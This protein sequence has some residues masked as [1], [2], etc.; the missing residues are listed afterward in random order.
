METEFD[1]LRTELVKTKTEALEYLKSILP[2]IESELLISNISYYNHLTDV[3]NYTDQRG[4]KLFIVSEFISLLSLHI[5]HIKETKIPND[6][7]GDSFSKIQEKSQQYIFTSN[8]INKL[9]TQKGESDRFE[10]N[11]FQLASDIKEEQSHIRN[12]AIPEHYEEFLTSLYLNYNDILKSKLGFNVDEAFKIKKGIVN[13]INNRIYLVSEEKSKFS[14]VL[15]KEIKYF[16]KKKKLSHN[17]ILTVDEINSFR[18]VSNDELFK[19]LFRMQSNNF[20][21][22]IKKC[23]SINSFLLSE[24]TG[25][26]QST[27]SSFLNKFSISFGEIDRIYDMTEGVTPLMSKPIISNGTNF[28]ISSLPLLSGAIGKVLDSELKQQKGKK[29]GLF[30]NFKHDFLLEKSIS[31]FAKLLNNP[32]HTYTNVDYYIDN[33]RY[34]LD[35][36]IISDNIAFIIEVKTQIFSE[37]AKKGYYQRIKKHLNDIITDSHSQSLRA[38]KL[39]KN[40]NE[41][42]IF[43]KNSKKKIINVENIDRFQSISVTLESLSHI[44][45]MLKTSNELSFF[46]DND[47]P[48]IICY[49]DLIIISD[50]LQSPSQFSLYLKRRE[51]FLS[52]KNYYTFDEIDVLSYFLSHYLDFERFNID[53]SATLFLA[54]ATDEIN[55]Y[56][57]YKF[58][59]SGKKVQKPKLD[60]SLEFQRIINRVEE[61]ELHYRLNICELLH[62]LSNDSRN[63]FI[64]YLKKI[65]KMFKSDKELHDFSLVGSEKGGWGITYMTCENEEKLQDKLVEYCSFKQRQQETLIWVGIGDSGLKFPKITKLLYLKRN[66]T[67][68]KVQNG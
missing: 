42:E 2:Q 17:G 50:L 44:S 49:Y 22:E 51:V 57:M 38:R 67:E 53:D 40:K 60:I 52:K 63:R 4:G 23:S 26:D 18:P 68:N 41:I 56:Y 30:K 21:E 65:R 16:R 58:G 15:E 36:L 3:D 62:D 33:D 25:I 46:M 13:C 45:P 24:V 64:K 55:Q 28:L 54:N 47:F 37:R 31:L 66:T 61:S 20:Y 19:I 14:K 7:L 27:I 8:F 9:D 48:L 39:F 10:L 1:D 34:E 59:I 35:G 5:G 29:S 32:I 12:P 6:E 43:P 11:E